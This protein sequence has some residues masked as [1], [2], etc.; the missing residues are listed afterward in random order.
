MPFI[1][2]GCSF[3]CTRCQQNEIPPGAAVCGRGC[4]GVVR[5]GCP[6]PLLALATLIIIGFGVWYFVR[7]GWTLLDFLNHWSVPAAG[8][9]VPIIVSWVV[10]MY[11]FRNYVTVVAPEPARVVSR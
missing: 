7:Q 9:A 4:D 10:L 6:G 8:I 3:T 5:R 11:T 1:E 2:P